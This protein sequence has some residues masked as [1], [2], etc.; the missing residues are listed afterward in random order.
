MEP[1]EPTF[2][3][4]TSPTLEP[5]FSSGWCEIEAV[6]NEYRWFLFAI[7]VAIALF[8]MFLI[9]KYCVGIRMAQ[10]CSLLTWISFCVTIS[11]AVSSVAHGLIVRR[12]LPECGYQRSH[13][14]PIPI[15]DTM[16]VWQLYVTS[17]VVAWLI[18]IVVLAAKIY[19]LRLGQDFED[20]FKTEYER[21]RGD[22]RKRV[23]SAS[24]IEITTTSNKSQSE[25]G[26]D[27]KS[28]RISKVAIVTVVEE[29]RHKCCCSACC[30]WLAEKMKY[31]IAK[32]K[33][34]WNVMLLLA[35]FVVFVFSFSLCATLSS[36]YQIGTS[37]DEYGDLVHAECG[38]IDKNIG[39][40]SEIYGQGL[41][42][43]LVGPLLIF[44]GYLIVRFL[45]ESDC[46]C[47]GDGII[48]VLCKCCG[49]WGFVAV[50]TALFLVVYGIGVILFV[51]CSPFLLI[52]YRS[53][54]VAEE[55]QDFGSAVAFD[56]AMYAVFLWDAIIV[57]L[58]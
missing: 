33:A 35:K 32:F 2:E 4:T 12:D 44:A 22:T 54:G 57:L 11:F 29:R 26:N 7:T 19:L 42:G 31:Q 56:I 3:P 39:R 25:G 47:D 10:F 48:C 55:M 36:L 45:A 6:D 37:Y 53:I 18:F 9:L 24:N 51:I 40:I 28:E 21:K 15:A 38:C 58:K 14:Y 17:M 46:E 50:V 27:N 13:I 8:L 5:T 1:T 52:G 20:E 30:R 34:G 23:T 41:V 49:L 43:C 16:S